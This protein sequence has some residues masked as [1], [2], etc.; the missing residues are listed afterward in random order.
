MTD[1]PT[2]AARPDPTDQPAESPKPTIPSQPIATDA[3]LTTGAT[4][5][6][7]P[8]NAAA[9]DDGTAMVPAPE[10]PTAGAT[11]IPAPGIAAPPGAGPATPPPSDAP[12]P[13]IRRTPRERLHS[14]RRL[15]SVMLVSGFRAAPLGMTASLLGGIFVAAAQVSYSVGYRLIV[16]GALRGNRTMVLT[17]IIGTAVLFTLTWMLGITNAM[18]NSILTDRVNLRVGEHIARLSNAP[19]GLDHFENP[20]YRDE[21]DLLRTNRRTLA[22]APRQVI[23]ILQLLV[24]SAF[25]LGLIAVIYP[26]I[27]LVPLLALAPMLADRRAARIQAKSEQ[28]LATDNRLLADLFTLATTAQHARELRVYGLTGPLA[29]RHRE[30]GEQL[31][32]KN[33]RATVRSAAWE[34]LGW[35]IFA[36]GFGVAVVVLTVRA[37]HGEESVGEVVMA[38]SLIRR[39][40]GQVSGAT[41]TSSSFA[42]AVRVAKRLIWLEDYAAKAR[43]ER[44]GVV[45]VEAPDRL[46][47]G[48]RFEAVEFAYPNAERPALSGVD[49]FLPAGATVAVVGDN[50]AGKTTLVKLLTGMYRPTGGRILVDGRDLAGIDPARWRERIRATFQDF[51]SYQFTAGRVI[52]VGDLP[53]V[54][55][56]EA[57]AV[58]AQDAGAAEMV[59]KFPNGLDTQ[60]GRFFRGGRE[61]SGGQWHKLALAR[62]LMRRTP[63]L[64]VLDEPTAS[65]DAAAESALF[66]RYASA[67]QQSARDGAITVLISHRFSTVRDA[68]VVIVVENG[69]I[70]ESG[71]H[72][73]LLAADGL[74]AKLHAMQAAHYK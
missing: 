15:T 69:R 43:S 65:L 40:Q 11:R 33:L 53:K 68:D 62:G 32:V 70:A 47:E 20:E 41:D 46:A 60:V 66:A 63:L 35:I 54:D 71:S 2:D 24:R 13:P 64:T 57:L 5:I 29:A 8:A 25:I 51:V 4:N 49:L 14:I 59:G 31:R 39:A 34:A 72:D 10:T 30:L 19:D 22:A 7:T 9:A 55:D 17:G 18:R 6:P 50:G 61:L 16:D 38:V 56:P 48:I 58:A 73:D 42:S 12:T 74:Y 26:P 52:G 21:L 23:A 36:A 37:V 1:Q 45:L 27:L 44:S 28:S 67:A 3:T